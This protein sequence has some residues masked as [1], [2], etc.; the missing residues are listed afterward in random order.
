MRQILAGNGPVFNVD[1]RVEANTSTL[2]QWVLVLLGALL[3]G[4]LGRIAVITG[5]LMTVTGVFIACDATRRL[6]STNAP[7]R[8]MLPAGVLVIFAVPP[9]QDFASAGLDSGLGTLWLSAC[10][11]LLVRLRNDP[12][13]LELTAHAVVY[14]LG[15]LVR[16]DLFLV[17]VIFFTASWLLRRPSFPQAAAQLAALGTLPISYEVFRAGY[18]GLLLPMPALTKEAGQTELAAGLR[19]LRDFADPYAL[20][21]PAALLLIA[22]CLIAKRHSLDRALLVPATPVCAALALTAYVTKVG[23][24]YM[25]ARML[26]PAT[27]LALLPVFLIPC[28]RALAA[29]T[30]S[31]ATWCAVVAGPW[32]TTTLDPNSQTVRVRVEDTRL[33]G[34]DNAD[35]TRAWTSA[36]PGLRESVAAALAAKTPVL[37]R[38]RPDDFR[39]DLLMPLNPMYKGTKISI[40][41]WYLGVTGAVVPLDQRIVEM[42]GLA[43]TL[44]AHLEYTPGW[45]K[46][47]PGHG[48]LIDDVWLLAL[49]LDPQVLDP[50]PGSIAVTREGLAAAR[51]ALSCGDLKELLD[52]TRKPLTAGRF[53]DNLT[54]AW[55]RTNLRIPRDPF[56]AE[57][58]F[59]GR[60]QP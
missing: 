49:D 51:H 39:P 9:F 54:G 14:G 25:H 22:A 18:Y 43:H 47:L 23:G 34:N 8:W 58:K 36:F 50:P 24:D 2:W 48:K 32:H 35:N 12:S 27:Y 11:W 38:L 5:L 41:G 15:V 40:P 29:I 13:P 30:V 26:L 17:T 7:T 42:W 31:I 3:P 59:C 60:R 33:T 52:S 16:P 57:R 4:D 28:T 53:W 19:Y 20:Y 45:E 10:W 44:G 55:E 56:D 6:Y 21:A 1:E 37:L 46:K